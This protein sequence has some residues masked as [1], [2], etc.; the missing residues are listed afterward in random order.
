M[1][2]K[3]TFLCASVNYENESIQMHMNYVQIQM[4]SRVAY[5]QRFCVYTYQIQAFPYS[6]VVTSFKETSHR[7]GTLHKVSM[8]LCMCK[9]YMHNC[10]MQKSIKYNMISTSNTQNSHMCISA[11][12]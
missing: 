9:H 4:N 2:I 10:E 3:L 5:T 11:G 6:V 12:S 8:Q 7:K 1:E